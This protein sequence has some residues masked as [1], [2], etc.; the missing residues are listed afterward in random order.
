VVSLTPEI[1]LVHAHDEKH[2]DDE[3]NE[4]VNGLHGPSSFRYHRLN[5]FSWQPDFIL[6]EGGALIDKTAANI[7]WLNEHSS[8]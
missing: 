6:L 4:A 2:A 3:L 5:L 8:P 7:G 1:E